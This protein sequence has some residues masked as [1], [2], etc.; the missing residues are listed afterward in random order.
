MRTQQRHVSCKAGQV[1]TV[2]FFGR[3]EPELTVVKLQVMPSPGVTFVDLQTCICMCSCMCTCSCSRSLGEGQQALKGGIL[4]EV[5]CQADN[6]HAI[7]RHS[8]L[9]PVMVHASTRWLYTV[10]AS[11]AEPQR[12]VVPCCQLPHK[13]YVL[14]FRPACFLSCRSACLVMW[15]CTRGSWTALRVFLTAM[16]RMQWRTWCKVSVSLGD[17]ARWCFVSAS[18]I[19][20]EPQ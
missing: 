7:Q 16:M 5:P 19:V 9:L 14:I 4:G 17:T 8:V 3:S 18:G 10:R 1:P 6:N 13:L 12:C 15:R 11:A 2:A 20:V